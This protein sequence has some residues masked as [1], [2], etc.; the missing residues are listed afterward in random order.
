MLELIRRVYPLLPARLR[1]VA[2]YHEARERLDGNRL[3]LITLLTQLVQ[4]L[5][6]ELQQLLAMNTGSTPAH[7]ANRTSTNSTHLN[8]GTADGELNV[9]GFSRI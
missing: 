2:P 4:I 6:Q 8:R 3:Q 5:E 7:S 9:H 1:H